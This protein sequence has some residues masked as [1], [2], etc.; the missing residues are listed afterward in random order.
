M[1][2]TSNGDAASACGCAWSRCWRHQLLYG[3]T[4][5]QQEIVIACA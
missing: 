5:C 4:N 2:R 1:Q 3:C